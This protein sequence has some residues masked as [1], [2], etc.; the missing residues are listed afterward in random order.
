MVEAERIMSDAVMAYREALDERLVAAY[1]LGSLAHGGFSP[2]VSDIDLGLVVADPVQPSDGGTIEAV[3][4]AQQRSG[5]A[6]AER[7]SVFWG[8]PS[9]L[10]GDVD[11]GR[12]PPLDRLDLIVN[13]RLL[14][15]ADARDDLPQPTAAE[16]LISGAEFALERLAGSC[17][18]RASAADEVRDPDLLLARGTRRVTKLVLFPVRFMFTAAT[19]HVGTNEDAARWYLD[20]DDATAAPLVDAARTWR[21]QDIKDTAAAARLL[22]EQLLPLY[23]HYIDDHIARLTVAGAPDLVRGFEQWRARLSS[24]T[25]ARSRDG[26]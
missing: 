15:G 4:D 11:G 10:R 25:T 6:L 3:A 19:G 12:F 13:G 5:P 20:L 1:A 14:E 16:L 8:T 23:R 22:R 9:T 17:A 21:V 18:D 24:C 2:L 7:L 26:R